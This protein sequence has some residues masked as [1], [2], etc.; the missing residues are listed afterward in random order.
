MSAL[1]KLGSVSDRDRKALKWEFMRN[2]KESPCQVPPD[3]KRSP[4]ENKYFTVLFMPGYCRFPGEEHTK[5]V[6]RPICPL[7]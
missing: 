5:G 7:P 1:N 3:E 4:D 6:S 2:P